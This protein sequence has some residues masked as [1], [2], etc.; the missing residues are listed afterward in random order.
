ML[1][2][3]APPNSVCCPVSALKSLFELHPKPDDAPLFISAND[4]PI[5][6]NVFIQRL[7]STL[8]AL[9]IDNAEY[10][11]HSFRRG[12]ATSAATAGFSD[13]EIQLMGRWKSNSYKLYIDMP[14]D[15]LLSLSSNLFSRGSQA[16]S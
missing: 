9:G 2:A 3:K 15:R 10:S 1:I 5:S 7:K 11:G 16:Q 12:A 13:Y 8:S 6:R 14:K 4:E